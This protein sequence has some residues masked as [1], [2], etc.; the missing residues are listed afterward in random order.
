[1]MALVASSGW[2]GCQKPLE[3]LDSTSIAS[4]N[5]SN[6]SSSD[7]RIGL[8]DGFVVWESNRSGRW[9]I[10]IRDLADG[11]PRQL[12]P[13]QGRRLHCCPHISPDGQRIAYMSLPPDQKGYPEGGATGT[14]FLI[15]PHG[16]APRPILSAA[17]NYYENRAAVWKSSTE[18]I[19]I[20]PEGFTSLFHTDTER[21]ERLTTTPES[22][23]PWLINSR[24]TWA[25][26]GNGAL[27]AY[28]P[29]KH[30]VA[31][32]TSL[33]GCQPYFSHD[34]H[35][36][37][38]VTA[39]G[40]PIDWLDLESGVS[41]RLL[42][43]SDARLPAGL[44]YLYFPMLS[45]DGRL[46]SFAASPDEHA[47]FEG[48][49]EIFV[50]ET[51]PASFEFLGP[52]MRF[53]YHPGTDRFP[54][55]FLAPLPLDRSYG[56]A[57]YRW[58]AKPDGPER[59]WNWDFG[60][61]TRSTAA[62]GEHTY[63]RPGRFKVQAVSGNRLLRGQVVVK[64]AQPPDV[65][66]VSLLQNGQEIVIL[67]DEPTEIT[68]LEAR[69]ESGILLAGQALDRDAR[70][71]RVQ[72]REPIRTR[73]RLVLSGV[74]DRAQRPNVLAATALTID[75]PRWPADRRG[76]TFLWETGDAPN[77][78]YDPEIEAETAIILSPRG[79]ARLDQNLTLAP[80]GGSFEASEAA[81]SRVFRDLKSTYEL[82]VEVVME[83][84]TRP[85]GS[86][87]T[88]LN[89]GSGSRQNFVL[90]QQD[91]YL[92]FGIRMRGRG[93][94][95]VPRVRLFDLP[96]GQR[97]HVVVTYSAGELVAYRNGELLVTDATIKGG[98]FQWR[99][100][101]LVFGEEGGGRN[102]WSGKL[103]GVAIYNRVLEQEE[104]QE[105]FLRYKEI[106]DSRP[107][108]GR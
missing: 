25:A 47:H 7:G 4:A 12:T 45:P 61:G 98:F 85:P 43:K 40:G 79:S 9:R 86:V 17:R 36:V 82:T 38:W 27:A 91:N 34:G 94:D 32:R 78:L 16:S 73:D 99:D 70:R 67:F 41:G 89:A 101:P 44:G 68:Q 21:S 15:A 83:P 39:P 75:P 92:L 2:L 90:E 5:D 33:R 49:Y 96:L 93:K 52:P 108:L 30:L 23:H 84:D 69:L 29:T 56:E 50:V 66:S 88:I 11:E 59:Q 105:G 58:S 53:T 102:A 19:Y 28:D 51:D 37:Y 8:G 3:N 60:D 35:W 103:E 107:R 104:V 72:L 55:V 26:S 13:D 42:R 62:V 74:A 46:F 97:S 63:E 10:W 54:D 24:L 22:K 65:I 106:L 20:E 57:P 95:A 48:D 71:L 64:P 14:M 87:G 76:L 81:A 1:M 31:G 80:N 6:P 77:L 18:L 100:A